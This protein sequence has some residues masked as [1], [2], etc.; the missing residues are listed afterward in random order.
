MD[1]G[2]FGDA[3]GARVVGFL[4]DQSFVSTSLPVSGGPQEYSFIQGVMVHLGYG[5]QV[6]RTLTL[7]VQVPNRS[8]L[9]QN[10]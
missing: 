8:I 5:S 10:L 9:V 4:S 6:G 1:K 3:V 7:R 2:K